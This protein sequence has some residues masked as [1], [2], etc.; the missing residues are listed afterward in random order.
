MI[1]LYFLNA[2]RCIRIAWLLEELGVEWDVI[3]SERGPNGLSPPDFKSQ[4]P[5][6]LGKAPTIKDSQTGAVVTESGAIIEYLCQR[7]PEQSARLFP[8]DL[9]AR[10]E[11]LEWLH[12]AEGTFA[13]HG[14]A[15]LYARWTI[16]EEAKH[17]MPGMEERLSR[18]IVNDFNWLEGQLQKQQAEGR[19]W[20]VGDGLTVADIQMQFT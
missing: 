1:T 2:S 5:S 12:G 15:L 9:V 8:T 10:A 18:N 11:V 6:A 20:I 13:V 17:T 7:F 3:R 19:D 14:M 4:I 16:A